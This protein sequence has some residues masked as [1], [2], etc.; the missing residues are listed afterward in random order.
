MLQSFSST[1]AAAASPGHCTMNI[2]CLMFRLQIS[3]TFL[4]FS[5]QLSAPGFDTVD[6]ESRSEKPVDRTFSSKNLTPQQWDIADNPQGDP[7]FLH[8]LG[9]FMGCAMLCL[10]ASHRC[11]SRGLTSTIPTSSRAICVCSTCFGTRCMTA[12]CCTHPASS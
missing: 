11:A 5:C 3:F 2:Q 12:I 8:S 10:H 9:I 7:E 1:S 6:D 4:F